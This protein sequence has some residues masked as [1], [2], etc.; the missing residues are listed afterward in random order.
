MD[1]APLVSSSQVNLSSVPTAIA[2]IYMAIHLPILLPIHLGST[3]FISSQLTMLTRH[4]I[5]PIKPP[6]FTACIC[7]TILAAICLPV[8]PAIRLAVLLSISATIFLTD[9][10]L[11][12]DNSRHH[13]WGCQSHDKAGHHSC[14]QHTVFH[15]TSSLNV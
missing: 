11:G 15:V 7:S 6:K 3:G 9:V 1:R 14:F 5:S 10:G 8:F 13:G 12:H 4:F 2:T